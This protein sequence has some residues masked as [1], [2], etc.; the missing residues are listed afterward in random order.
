[1]LNLDGNPK[2]ELYYYSQDVLD[3]RHK[4]ITTLTSNFSNTYTYTY[5]EYQPSNGFCSTANLVV[6]SFQYSLEKGIS[7]EF[8]VYLKEW[9]YGDWLFYFDDILSKY[10]HSDDNQVIRLGLVL[11]KRISDS[12]SSLVS[13]KSQEEGRLFEELQTPRVLHASSSKQRARIHR[14][15]SREIKRY[16]SKEQL[17]REKRTIL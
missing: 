14:T 5:D 2:T 16:I 17:I 9:Y 15:Y 7:R 8:H 13:H 6:D 12:R 10:V 3:F 1:M 4:Y 11:D